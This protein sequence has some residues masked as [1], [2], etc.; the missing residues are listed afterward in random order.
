MLFQF[1]ENPQADNS[2]NQT[3][4]TDKI[5]DY[6]VSGFDYENRPV[7]VMPWGSW[8]LVWL[9]EHPVLKERFLKHYNLYIEDV[10]TGPVGKIK[11]L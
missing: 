11:A 5:F 1:E 8:D 7:V 3:N 2:K 4:S 10:R 9:V 6:F